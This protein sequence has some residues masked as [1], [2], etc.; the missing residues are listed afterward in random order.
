MHVSPN[1]VTFIH[2]IH[3]LYA[4]VPFSGAF[5]LRKYL[6]PKGNLA[7]CIVLQWPL[8]TLK[9]KF[10]A[11]IIIICTYMLYYGSKMDSVI[12]YSILR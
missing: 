8:H 3:T 10:P 1:A 9:F 12:S 4:R 2:H 5:P 7:P 6:A 11:L